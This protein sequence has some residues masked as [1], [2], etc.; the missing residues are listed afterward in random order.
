MKEIRF[1]IS[2]K[3]KGNWVVPAVSRRV[4]DSPKRLGSWCADNGSLWT[5][6][7][8][9]KTIFES[10]D[11]ACRKLREIQLDLLQ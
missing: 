1:T 3:R 8:D 6:L 9:G 5:S 10:E 7:N 2:E 11:E 4:F